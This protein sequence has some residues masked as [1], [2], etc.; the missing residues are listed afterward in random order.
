MSRQPNPNNILA[1][2][3]EHF[4]EIDG[5]VFDLDSY[6][7]HCAQP[8]APETPSAPPETPAPP[9][10][11]AQQAQPAPPDTDA[12]PAAAAPAAVFA[13]DPQHVGWYEAGET[14]RITYPIMAG[15]IEPGQTAGVCTIQTGS[16][17]Y[18][19]S[20]FSSYATSFATSFVTSY[21][22]GSGSWLSSYFFGSGSWLS[23]YF[24]GSGSWLSSYA[25]GSWLS[26]YFAGSGQAPV[27][28]V[29]FAGGY[30]LELI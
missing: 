15:A 5:V 3:P 18:V 22:L 14:R 25:A 27:P 13:V 30:G 1:M 24:A 17:S 10:P 12:Q 6:A 26:S 7:R 23:S 16:G 8:P 9:A 20:F 19:S 4:R 29:L 11:P 2:D 28:A 21:L